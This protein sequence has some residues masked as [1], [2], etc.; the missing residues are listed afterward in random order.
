MVVSD[1]DVVFKSSPQV[2]SESLENL[3]VCG[4]A[5][6]DHVKEA[7]VSNFARKHE[8]HAC[9]YSYLEHVIGRKLAYD[10]LVVQKETC[11]VDS[12][13][14]LRVRR[15]V[16]RG[17][18]RQSFVLPTHVVVFYIDGKEAYTA[19]KHLTLKIS[20][21]FE[22]VLQKGVGRHCGLDSCRDPSTQSLKG[23]RA[24]AV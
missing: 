5:P 6:L 2:D 1:Q 22:G 21:K 4:E 10:K 17:K 19:F 11:S 18:R 7:C 8:T 15:Y 23:L 14:A 13:C 20:Y 9:T 16:L 12:G 3:F 24:T